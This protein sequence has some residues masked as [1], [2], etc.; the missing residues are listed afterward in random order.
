MVPFVLAQPSR[1]SFTVLPSDLLEPS[2]RRDLNF[3]AERGILFEQNI[4]H[5]ADPTKMS[6]TFTK[7][8]ETKST[9]TQIPAT[10][11]DEKT[12]EQVDDNNIDN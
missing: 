1:S 2:R 5:N 9:Q 11:S 3:F 8:T 10:D 6:V 7:T 4:D 12:Y